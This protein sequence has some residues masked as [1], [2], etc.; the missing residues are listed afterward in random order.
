MFLPFAKYGAPSSFNELKFLFVFAQLNS[1]YKDAN[2]QTR[3]Y[4]P[5]RPFHHP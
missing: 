5:C 2:L 3:Q 4:L 1:S